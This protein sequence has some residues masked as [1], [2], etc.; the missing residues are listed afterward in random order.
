[1]A[2][3]VHPKDTTRASA[4]ELWMNAPNPMVT[5]IKTF[6]VTNLVRISRKKQ[7]KFNMLMDY[8]IPHDENSGGRMIF[9]SFHLPI[10][11]C[12]TMA[13]LWP[14]VIWPG[15]ETRQ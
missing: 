1:M 13:K 15:I 11:P 3:E 4:Y 12:E 9:R 10:W 6:D 14:K 5:F 8:C 2:K 7:L